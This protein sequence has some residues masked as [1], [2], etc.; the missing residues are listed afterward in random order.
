MGLILEGEES[1]GGGVGCGLW[2][3]E[4]FAGFPARTLGFTWLTAGL[5]TGTDGLVLFIA[6]LLPGTLGLAP[7]TVGLVPP[8]PIDGLAPPTFGISGCLC[9]PSAVRSEVERDFLDCSGAV[10]W[11]AL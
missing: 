8:I 9:V 2:A 1:F 11:V 4:V 5:F 3:G 6:G 10:R 7:L